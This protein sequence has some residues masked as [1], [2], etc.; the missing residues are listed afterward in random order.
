MA[1]P[2]NILYGKKDMTILPT[3]SVSSWFGNKIFI[4]SGRTSSWNII[5]W[6]TY[7]YAKETT[8]RFWWKIFIR[9]IRNKYLT[10]RTLFRGF[11]TCCGLFISLPDVSHRATKIKSVPD[12]SNTGFCWWTIFFLL[13]KSTFFVII[14]EW[15]YSQLFLKLYPWKRCLHLDFYR[16]SG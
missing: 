3:V 11:A 16:L 6:R 13:K 15:R 4:K 5:S 7:Q 9:L 2:R 1:K 12:Y 8:N 14:F 10:G